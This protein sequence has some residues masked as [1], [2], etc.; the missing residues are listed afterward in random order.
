M[1]T[2]SPLCCLVGA[3]D[4]GTYVPIL[5]EE[6]IRWFQLRDK[7]ST[8][9]E[10]FSAGILLREITR[11]HDV[12]LIVNDHPDI[13]LAVD[14]DGV[15]LGQDDLPIREARK[16]MGNRI[17]GISTHSLSEA[18]AAQEAGADY[19]GFGPVFSTCTK[20]A[21]EAK[22][23]EALDEVVRGVVVPVIAIGGI[24]PDNAVSVFGTGCAGI[25]ASAG[26]L[27]GDPRGNARR[28]VRISSSAPSEEQRRTWSKESV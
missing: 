4:A 22:G 24:T 14:A 28:F 18:I 11:R 8:R 13:A 21:G 20:D 15:H 10:I 9:R 6:G 17:I 19:I 7:E 5:I 3:S 27:R 26:F 2:C 16:V 1:I 12:L 25:A 23:I